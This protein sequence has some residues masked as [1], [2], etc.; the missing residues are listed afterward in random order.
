M[1]QDEQIE[2]YNPNTQ[3]WVKKLPKSFKDKL[4]KTRWVKV[5]LKKSTKELKNL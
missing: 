3:K 5:E 1:K 2:Y 4:V